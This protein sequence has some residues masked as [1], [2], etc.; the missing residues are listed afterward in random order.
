MKPKSYSVVLCTTN[1]LPTIIGWLSGC[2]YL[3]VSS[4]CSRW[5]SLSL[6]TLTNK[7]KKA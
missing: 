6:F 5:G 7:W 4:R 3:Q 1:Y 2:L